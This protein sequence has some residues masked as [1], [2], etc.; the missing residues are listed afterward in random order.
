MFEDNDNT[1]TLTGI[2][3]KIILGIGI[4]A[5]PLTLAYIIYRLFQIL[6]AD[7]TRIM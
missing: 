2:T 5:V 4:V 1:N 7:L 6:I 3:A